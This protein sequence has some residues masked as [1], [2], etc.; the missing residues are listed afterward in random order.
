MALEQLF[1]C[2]GGT[3]SANELYARFRA[4]ASDG[5][6]AEEDQIAARV[7]RLY[8]AGLLGLSTRSYPQIAL[9]SEHPK[10][11]ALAVHQLSRGSDGVSTA[12]NT[13]VTVDRFEKALLMACKGTT[14]ID[15]L[16]EGMCQLVFEG[17][18]DVTIS[19]VT[20]TDESVIREVVT[21][22]VPQKFEHLA[23]LGLVA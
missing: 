6:A 18:L 17:E 7:L 11:N 10:T 15:A 8:A 20:A 5:A 14:S 23:R 22:L 4:L 16:C 12:E 21:A 19:G 2:G 9:N 1:L 13:Y 3:V